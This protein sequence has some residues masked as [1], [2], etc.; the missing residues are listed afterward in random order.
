MDVVARAY[1]LVA[2]RYAQRFS[3]ELEQKPFDRLLLDWLVARAGTS[4]ILCDLGCGPGHVA[5]YLALRGAT[6]V[7]IDISS[8]MLDQARARWP[9]LMFQQADMRTLATFEQGTFAAVVALYSIIHLGQA[10]LD[11]ALRA[12]RRTLKPNGWFLLAFHVGD[13]AGR[14]D[15]FLGQSV[16][17]DFHLHRPETMRDRLS[18]AGFAVTEVIER[19]PDE[20]IELPTRR[21]YIWARRRE[22]FQGE[23][24]ARATPCRFKGPAAR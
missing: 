2:E 11:Q 23:D 18:G 20:K 10:D 15:E 13:E 1:D 14:I 24:D 9:K 17:F 5:G 22:D 6:V 3:S 12:I 7:G 21:A 19:Y 4:G 8:G 16:A